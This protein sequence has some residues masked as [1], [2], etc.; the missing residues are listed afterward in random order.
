MKKFISGLLVG[1]ILSMCIGVYAVGINQFTATKATFPVLVN[2]KTFTTDKPI[3]VINGSTYMPLKAIGDVL[4][5]KVSWNNDLGRVEVGETQVDI[6]GYSYSNPAPLNTAQTISI[7]DYSKKYTAQVTVK[8]I[9]RGENAWSMIQQA[10]QFNEAAPSGYDY[11]LAKINIKVLDM[12]DGKALS[13]MPMIDFN[14]ISSE[15]KEYEYVSVVIPDPK[16]ES[17]LYK[18]SSNEGWAVFTVKTTDTNPK[19]TFGRSYDGTGG[20]WFKAY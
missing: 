15:G 18:G 12:A 7:D 20:I 5:V 1:V 4:G 13:V 19:I 10:N 14:L 11:I 2:G 6:G 8:D 17:N 3:V 16:L 9:V